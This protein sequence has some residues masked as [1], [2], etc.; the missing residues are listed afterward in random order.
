MA[1]EDEVVVFGEVFEKEAK[2]TE[3]FDGDEVGVVDDGDDDFSFGV[4]VARFCDESG[5]AFV[6]GSVAFEVEGLAE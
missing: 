5:F 6:I 1:D 3:G 2:F 4:E